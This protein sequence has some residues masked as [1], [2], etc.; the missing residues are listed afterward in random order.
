M[1]VDSIR[2]SDA[3]NV[4]TVRGRGQGRATGF[5]DLMQSI[6]GQGEASSDAPQ[7][8]A[9]RDLRDSGGSRGRVLSDANRSGERSEEEAIGTRAPVED[10][11]GVEGRE[12][13][14]AE[15][16]RSDSQ[17]QS[18]AG[19]DEEE[20]RAAAEEIAALQAGAGVEARV[21]PVAEAT[22]DLA[23]EA[24]ITA[25]VDAD[26]PS[27]AAADATGFSVL[28]ASTPSV[29]AVSTEV[30]EGKFGESFAGAVADAA[31]G[32]AASAESVATSDPAPE[33]PVEVRPHEAT[34]VAEGESPAETR[35]PEAAAVASTLAERAPRAATAPIS[36]GERSAP[37]PSANP[38]ESTRVTDSIPRV[39]Q[40]QSSAR[41]D[42]NPGEQAPE[43]ALASVSPLTASD[44]RSRSTDAVFEIERA[45]AHEANAVETNSDAPVGVPVDTTS[46]PRLPE[47]SSVQGSERVLPIAAPETIQA[48]AEWLATQ[49]GGTARLVLH[50]PELGEIAIRVT[51]RHQAVTVEMVAHTAIA[52]SIAEEQSDRLAQAFAS[53]DLRLE[54]FE[55]RRSDPSDSS[56]T[57]QFGSSDAGARERER[58]EEER[59]ASRGPSGAALRRGSAAGNESVASTTRA[60]NGR[61]GGIDLRI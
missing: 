20:E 59:G 4:D 6:L 50:P 58:A 10:E 36:T 57:G 47:S 15:A 34:S 1:N 37:Q 7:T 55:V 3:A 45:A 32:A 25:P 29:E 35:T 43:R 53:R 8:P 41:G 9:T 21:V 56:S 38:V 27:V 24:P 30:P 44:K 23:A 42:S 49:G 5:A 26:A 13:V 19:R 48:R 33:P 51:V 11:R 60:P 14:D 16:A 18:D 61:S 12:A 46:V 40:P 52:R 17:G 39:L 2:P 28:A 54:Q 31:A 22:L